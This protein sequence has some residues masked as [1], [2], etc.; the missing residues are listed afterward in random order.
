[1]KFLIAIMVMFA[2]KATAEPVHVSTLMLD[3]TTT[4]AATAMEMGGVFR[5]YFAYGTT[6][7]G[8]GACAVKVQVSNDNASW[9]DLGTITLTLATTVA[10]DG[11][12]TTAPWK[13]VRGNIGSISGTGAKCSL[14]VGA[15]GK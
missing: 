4:G 8:A 7:A 11:L 2:M 9:V 5:T 10:G 13:Y 3:R 1:M 15:T 6:T 14:V 12:A